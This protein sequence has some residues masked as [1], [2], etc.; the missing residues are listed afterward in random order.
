M[1]RN[2]CYLDAALQNNVGHHAN[3]CGK[4]T[5][6][7]RRGGIEVDILANASAES[8]LVEELGLHPV[9]RHSPYSRISRGR[10]LNFRLAQASF[11]SDLGG[12]TGGRQYDLVYAGSVLPAQMAGVIRW[13]QTRYGAADMPPVAVE[14]SSPSGVGCVDGPAGHWRQMP[15]QYRS[16]A[17][18]IAKEYSDK[19]LFFTFDSVT[20]SDYSRLFGFEVETLPHV[21]SGGEIRHRVADE[22]GRP[23]VGFLGH[24]RPEKG[25][26][27]I[28]DVLRLLLEKDV[29]ARFLIHNA[30][31]RETAIA[32]ELRELAAADSRVCFDQQPADQSYWNGLLDR[33]DIAIL[34]YEPNRYAASFSG[35]AVEAV[36]CGL[37]IIGPNGT[38]MKTLAE[39][40]QKN[41]IGITDWTVEA[42]ADAIVESLQD[43]PRLSRSAYEGAGEWALENSVSAFVSRLQAFARNRGP[44]RPSPP[45]P[46]FEPVMRCLGSVARAKLKLRESRGRRRAQRR[47]ARITG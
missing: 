25:Y 27:L 41:S 26:H 24:Q 6:G 40:Y 33:T 38:T 35:V 29:R 20:S 17:A 15:G 22:Q 5:G 19:F 12:M 30:D 10:Y 14:F 28:P 34:P 7:L 16:A 18:E 37:P 46:P 39:R 36:S 32:R 42:I 45:T 31:M 3:V 43:F 1:I 23:V 4:I 21:Q 2:V 47:R 9:F 44:A 13:G 8:G 11:L